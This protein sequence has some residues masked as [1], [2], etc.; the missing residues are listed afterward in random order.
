M[1]VLGRG[2]AGERDGEAGGEVTAPSEVSRIAEARVL[3]PGNID[4]WREKGRGE[5][6]RAEKIEN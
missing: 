1:L 2:V 4:S 5:K 3:L 6:E